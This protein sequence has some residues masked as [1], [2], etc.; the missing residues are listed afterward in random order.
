MSV[1]AGEVAQGRWDV[2]AGQ[3]GRRADR[4]ATLSCGGTVLRDVITYPKTQK[5]TCLLTDAPTPVAESQLKELV[6]ASTAPQE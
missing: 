3:A 1:R 6:I 4:W 2:G 5:G